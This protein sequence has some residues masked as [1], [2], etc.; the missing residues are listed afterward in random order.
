MAAGSKWHKDSGEGERPRKFGKHD[1]TPR[2]RFS[3]APRV[4]GVRGGRGPGL[5]PGTGGLAAGFF[6]AG[7]AG[8][9]DFSN[10]AADLDKS[11]AILF[12]DER[13]FMS[14]S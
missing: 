2:K 5:R 7:S 4:P 8:I 6:A 3:D 13:A 14:G 11:T 9:A 10:H 12:G 1:F